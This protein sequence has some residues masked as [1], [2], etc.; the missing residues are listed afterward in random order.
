MAGEGESMILDFG[1]WI[2]DSASGACH[3]FAFFP[4]DPE[5]SEGSAFVGHEREPDRQ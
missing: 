5:R 3:W 2:L 4:R 1:F